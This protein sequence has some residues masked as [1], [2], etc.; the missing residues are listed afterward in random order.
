MKKRCLYRRG[1]LVVLALGLVGCGGGTDADPQPD[2]ARVET[3]R[4]GLTSGT[5]A[6]AEEETVASQQ[7]V[8]F[9][10]LRGTFTYGGDVPTAAPILI[11]KDQAVCGQHNL[12]DESLTVNPANKGIADVVL[13]LTVG[14]GQ[15]LPQPH[16]SYADTANAEVVLNNHECRYEPHVAL[17]RTGQTLVVANADPVGHNTKIDTQKN[18]PVN[19]M[20]PANDRVTAQFSKEER[21][22]IKASCSIHPWMSGYVVIKDTPYMA[23]T[24]KDGH[25]T[26]DNLPAGEWQ[27]QVWQEKLGPVSQATVDGQAVT[28]PKGI[29][30]V[31]IEADGETELNVVLAGT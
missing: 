8:G 19:P 24:D 25:F 12:V 11:T 23:V 7:P 21:M 4:T 5:T 27:F 13:F 1:W 16:P 28:W 30:T 3:I 18:P 31:K 6:Q 17:L 15:S 22:P 29:M 20:I 26:I 9:G 2:L 10:T 14:R